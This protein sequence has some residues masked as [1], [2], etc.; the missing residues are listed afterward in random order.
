MPNNPH[1][2]RKARSNERALL[3]AVEQAVVAAMPAS[4]AR[5]GVAVSGG[6]DS[7][8]LLHAALAAAPGRV[9]AVHVDHGLS[10]NSAKVASD[11]MAAAAQL[12]A[13]VWSRRVN[14]LRRGSLEAS[15]RAARYEALTAALAECQLDILWLAH[16]RRDQA[17]TVLGRVL[18]GTS[19]QGLGAMAARRGPYARPLL[20]V[21]RTAISAYALKHQLPVWHDSMNDD[22]R[23][24]RVRLRAL[25]PLLEAFN[26]RLEDA[27]CRLG[28]LAKE[29]VL[30]T[31]IV[32]PLPVDVLRRLS[33]AMARQTI[34]AQSYAMGLRPEDQHLT[35]ALALLATI[36]GS[37]GIDVPGGRIERRYDKLHIVPA[38]SDG[39][40]SPASLHPT[41]VSRPEVSVHGAG[42]YRVRVSQPGDRIRLAR[43]GGRSRLVSRLFIDAKIPR[44]ERLGLR[45]VEN[46]ETGQ[47]EWVERLGPAWQSMATVQ[48]D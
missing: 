26:P 10:E 34:A 36:Q 21:P 17:E 22:V 33:P 44:A 24:L 39:F 38:R 9:W 5:V 13:H 14:V 40:A 41:L 4:P 29:T 48:V 43:L 27:L 32:G 30:H 12:G 8:T 20:G 19:L 15:A 7:M 45:V 11:V 47:L 1:R 23:F 3:H 2:A 37:R 46:L 6:M 31:D 28:R 18:R 35:A 25:W 16:T 42:T